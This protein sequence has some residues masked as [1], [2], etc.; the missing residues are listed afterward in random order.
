MVHVREIAR[1]PHPIGTDEHRRVREYIKRVLTDLG[2]EA[3][4]SEATPFVVDGAAV[5]GGRIRNLVARIPGRVGARAVLVAGH[6]DTQPNT[7]GAA[8][9]GSAVAAMLEAARAL[10]WG[11]RLENDL[12]FLFSDAE[13]IGLLGAQ[14]FV[15]EHPL[16]KKVALVLNL[17]ARG[18]GGVSFTFETSAQNGRIMSEYAQAVRRPFAGSVMV[19]IYK[20]M[21]NNTDFTVFRQAGYAGFNVAFVDGFVHY[22]AMTDTPENLDRG[23]LQHQGDYIMDLAGHFGGLDL[24]DLKEKDQV[25]FN[26]VGSW[27][28]LVPASWQTLLLV[29]VVLLLILA[30]ALGFLRGRLTQGTLIGGIVSY[31]L[32]LA[33][34]LG[35]VFLVARRFVDLYPLSGHYYANNLPTAPIFF[36]S[37]AALALLVAGL[38]DRLMQR[39]LNLESRSLG[40]LFVLTLMAGAVHHLMPTGA[41]TLLYPLALPLLAWVLILGFDLDESHPRLLTALLTLSLLPGLF[42]LAPLVKMLFVVFSIQ[43]VWVAA[44]LL[45][46]LAGL[47]LSWIGL[48]NRHAPNWLT[49]PLLLVVVAAWGIGHL[50]SGFGVDAPLHSNLFYLHD[51]DQGKAFWVSRHR[52]PDDGNRAFFPQPSL[53]PLTEIFPGSKRVFLQNVAPV[54][55][56]NPFIWEVTGEGLG[57]QGERWVRGRLSS[58]RGATVLRLMIPGAETVKSL[59]IDDRPVP[60]G[61]GDLNLTYHGLPREGIDIRMVLNGDARVDLTVLELSWGLPELPGVA[62]MPPGVIPDTGW[63]SRATV[64]KRRVR[65]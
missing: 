12:I 28:L 36:W 24:E 61:A 52:E 20:R 23:S 41:Y 60:L 14:A 5:T 35:T 44:A 9:D 43:L 50:R 34:A 46:I 40:A 65:L 6:Y 29:A 26:P 49:L 27:L 3:E 15:D 62:D 1:K 31:I 32:A 55:D 48:L 42:L 64:V 57:D 8:D 11:R 56:L 47:M 17:E 16:A 30:L 37:F 25:F 33:L 59:D 21:P 2:I 19:E 51:A 45:L 63:F 22:H 10:K 58:P 54:A 4:V 53:E 18:N 7:P 39:F 38:L 13:E